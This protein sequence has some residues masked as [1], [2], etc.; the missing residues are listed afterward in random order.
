MNCFYLVCILIREDDALGREEDNLDVEPERP[1]LD[2]P[3]VSADALFH[4]PQLLGLAAESRN[5][6]PTR[7]T[8]L[9]EMANHVFVYQAAVY[10]SVMQHVRTRTHDAHVALQHVDKLRELIDV[11][12]SHEVAEGNFLG[13][14][15]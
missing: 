1:V 9:G 8:R 4:L 13:R 5:L 15:W 3:D 7:D 12:L 14:P 11:R 10:L 6:S 2:I